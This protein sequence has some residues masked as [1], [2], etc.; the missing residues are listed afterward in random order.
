MGFLEENKDYTDLTDRAIQNWAEKSGIV[1][2][3]QG[4][5]GIAALDDGSVQKVLH[6][7]APIQKRNYVLLDVKA[8]LV[9]DERKALFAKWK[10]S[11]FKR[12]A[13]VMMGEPPKAFINRSQEL[14]LKQKQAAADVEFRKKQDEEKRKRQ[15]EKQ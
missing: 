6:K 11:G 9:P 7:V 14:I 13:A 8:N 3:A 4:T 5:T 10:A 12:T 2:T 1:R 15:L